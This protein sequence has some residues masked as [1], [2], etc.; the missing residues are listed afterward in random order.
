MNADSRE[1]GAAK[2]PL[3]ANLLS[4]LVVAIAGF[5][6]LNLTFLLYFVVFR[7]FDIFV[8]GSPESI[9]QWIV[10]VR[11]AVFLVII[12]LASWLVFRS[13]LPVLAK[14]TFLTVPAAVILVFTGIALYD[15]QVLSYIIGVLIT[16]GAV[17]YFYRTHRHWLYY[18]SVI[19]TALALMIFGLAGGE[20]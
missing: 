1:D 11:S 10:P 13:K 8:R 20:I 3:D 5:V 17:L 15:F 18:Y 4:A 12:A 14:A 2:K 7:F 9:P 19:L 16:L 6:L